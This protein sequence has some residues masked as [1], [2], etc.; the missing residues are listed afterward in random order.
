MSYLSPAL[1]R[2]VDRRT[3]GEQE[4]VVLATTGVDIAAVEATVRRE[5]DMA[6][7]AAV[8]AEELGKLAMGRGTRD[9]LVVALATEHRTILGQVMAAVSRAIIMTTDAERP[10]PEVN[11]RDPDVDRLDHH[12][13][14]G[15]LTCPTVVGAT[16][17]QHQPVI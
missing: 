9:Y 14:D 3:K 15:R 1:Q 10:C 5:L 2:E 17:A 11:F 6:K 7:Q 16:L 12:S 8:I 13:H 4:S